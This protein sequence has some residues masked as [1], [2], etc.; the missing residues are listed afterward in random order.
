MSLVPSPPRLL[1]YTFGPHDRITLGYGTP[2]T[3]YLRWVRSDTDSYT[4]E[5]MDR[6]GAFEQVTLEQFAEITRSPGYRYEQDYYDLT[7]NRVR[8][9]RGVD[10][11]REI[12]PR[13][14]PR[15]RFR[16]SIV[17]RVM[18]RCNE[19]AMTLSDAS[20][21]ENLPLIAKEIDEERARLEGNA[22]P[23][24]IIARE[25]MPRDPET[26]RRWRNMFIDG[27]YN[28][29]ALRANYRNCG[30]DPKQYPPEFAEKI[31][32]RVR[33]YASETEPSKA[34]LYLNLKGD[35]NELNKVRQQAG[36]E[37]IKPP[38]F[39]KFSARIDAMPKF[40]VVAGR[41]GIE[42]ASRL[43]HPS[44]GGL[45]TFRPGERV[46]FDEFN[47]H[48][49]TIAEDTALWALLPD[50]I[51]VRIARGRWWASAAMDHAS[52]YWLGLRLVRQPS[53]LSALATL[54]MVISDKGV[55]ADAVGALSPWNGAVVPFI[56]ATDS[57]S[58]NTG[59]FQDALLGVGGM[60][61]V[62]T[63]G[64]P[65]LRGEL[66]RSFRTCDTRLLTRFSGR[67]F[68]DIVKLGDYP[69]E[70]RASIT[71]E[72]LA[73]IL[74]RY[75]VDIYHNTPHEGLNGQT[76]ANAYARGVDKYG[77]LPLPDNHVRR[78]VFG[79]KLKRTL[80][81]TGVRVLNLFSACARSTTTMR[82]PRRRRRATMCCTTRRSKARRCSASSAARSRPTGASPRLSSTRSA[83]GLASAASRGPN[84]RPCPAANSRAATL[85]PSPAT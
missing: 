78:N 58:W 61:L 47:V 32:A 17:L 1:R 3:R 64:L 30:S 53:T 8:A 39:K 7:N 74:V 12:P 52:R 71:D 34:G 69:A 14:R 4:F 85:R 26:I 57:A 66:E 76:P 63:T 29:A 15:V 25:K 22:R 65:Q 20:I 18:K 9:E 38:C 24:S 2:K 11:Y 72:Q 16:L 62:P 45:Q 27:G 44:S 55:Y 31:T 23:G 77:L 36:L 75:V 6:R 5:D 82:A 56:P 43:F 33:Q 70:A 50:D 46:E 84:S 35:F 51:K 54:S 49:H 19:K 41:K 10:A 68:G 73:W 80:R 83:A 42:F 37:A 67:A 79:L 48:L 81:P 59:A 40:A 21:R 13:E 60:P 28:A